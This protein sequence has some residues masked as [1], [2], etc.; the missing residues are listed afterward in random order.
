MRLD[1]I[2]FRAGFAVTIPEARQLI[3]HGHILVNNRKINIPSYAC[4]NQDKITL[5]SKKL[6]KIKENNQ[7]EKLT[8]PSHLVINFTEL[9]INILNNF[10]Y[11]ET[12]LKINELLVVEYYSRS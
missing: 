10:R 5:N 4:Q 7:N 6:I 2:L 8:T 1:N 12:G 9:Q 11:D 3:N